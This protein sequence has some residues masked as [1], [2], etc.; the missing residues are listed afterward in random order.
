MGKAAG[1]IMNKL[2]WR[3]L[4]RIFGHNFKKTKVLSKV[5]LKR[6]RIVYRCSRC[7][8]PMIIRVE[9]RSR[10]IAKEIVLYRRRKGIHSTMELAN[11]IRR[12]ANPK[13]QTKTMARVFQAFRIYVNRE[14]DNLRAFLPQVVNLLKVGG[15]MVIISY[16]SLEDREVKNFIRQQINPCTC[17]VEAPICT[18]SKTPTLRKVSSLIRPTEL[19]V[20]DNA[21]SRSARMRVVEK[22]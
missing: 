22:I 15:R 12:V 2:K 11:I 14:I 16:H 9:K 20:S 17:P 8:E 18:C 5:S 3:W 7:F 21:S 1:L 19:E 10:K 4:C 6:K 13:Y